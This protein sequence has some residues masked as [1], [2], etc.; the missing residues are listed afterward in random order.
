ME[1]TAYIGVRF[2]RIDLSGLLALP[3]VGEVYA[4]YPNTSYTPIVPTNMEDEFGLRPTDYGAIIEETTAHGVHR[5]IY[6]VIDPYATMTIGDIV[7]VNTT[8]A[9]VVI[10]QLPDGWEAEPYYRDGVLGKV[11]KTITIDD[12]AR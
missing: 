2:R 9:E 10:A 1:I 5:K 11:R 6:V 8:G 7:A 12:F 4:G 3:I